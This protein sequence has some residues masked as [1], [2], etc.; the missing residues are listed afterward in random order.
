MKGVYVRKDSPYYWIRY[1]DKYQQD[2]SKKRQSINTKIEVTPSDW[3][4]YK[5]QSKIIGT[6]ELRD[7][8]KSFKNGLAQRNIE[9]HSGVKLHHDK[10]LSEGYEE[11]KQFRTV[12]GSKSEIKQKTLSNYGIAVDHFIEA[13]GD[14]LIYKY[15]DKDYADLLRFFESKNLSRNSRSIYTRAL[16]TLWSYFVQKSYTIKNIIEPVEAETK[17]PDPIPL[18][19][20][21]TI[22]EYFKADADYPHHFQ[23]VYF[24]LLT[25]CRPSSAIMQL[26]E[27][28]DFKG[29]VITI[30]NVKSG[31]RKGKEFYKFPL[32]KELEKLLKEMKADKRTGRLFDMYS[33]VPEHYTWPLS[34]WKRGVAS[35]VKANKILKAYSL[36]QIRPT[37]ASF[38]INHLKIDIF[39]VKKLLDHT[40]VKVTDKHYIDFRVDNVRRELD[41]LTI[42]KFLE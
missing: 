31:R 13:S 37:L 17:D 35:L 1:Y 18:D 11:F 7:K 15:H 22:I 32:Y 42:N 34:F 29:K 8:L 27:D 16:K 41:E 28:I 24:L 10:I 4:R 21:F 3:K 20:M 14:K 25:G 23:I 5:E 39:T 12:P 9:I 26:R 19:D 40:D 33:I 38:L 30:R 2:E 6:S 36:K